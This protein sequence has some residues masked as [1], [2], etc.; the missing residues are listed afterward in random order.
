MSD[1]I[2]AAEHH[3]DFLKEWAIVAGNI[4]AWA[5]SKGFWPEGEDRNDGEMLALMHSEL[6]ECLEGLRHG[7]PPDD[8]V[9]EFT[10]AEVELADLVIRLMDTC[11]ARG[12]RV[13]DAIL[14]K[15]AYNEGR[16]HKHG[17]QF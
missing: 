1:T 9:P 11:V 4:H 14:A 10:S 17:K 5:R 12:W 6:S 2:W 13:S 7:N 15:M 8:M 3:K 16:P